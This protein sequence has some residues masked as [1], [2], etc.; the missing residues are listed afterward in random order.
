MQILIN[1]LYI[2]LALLAI[3]YLYYLLSIR[4]K[5][6]F[7]WG[8][9]KK[10]A[11]ILTKYPGIR[12]NHRQK[13]AEMS[14]EVG[15]LFY[16]G[17]TVDYRKILDFLTKM[18]SNPSFCNESDKSI[19]LQIDILCEYIK[20][21]N[22]YINVTFESA[23]LFEKIENALNKSD[24]VEAKKFLDLL[25]IQSGFLED[26]LRRKGKKEFWIGTALGIL[27]LALPISQ[28]IIQ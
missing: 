20:E 9:K 8:R 17:T 11:K 1:I 16:Y 3:W 21:N 13:L 18:R 6:S 14:T 22:K 12:R 10:I 4:T 25:Y 7:V 2:A 26:G 19:D 15:R 28:L 27:G 5:R 24:M 23:Q